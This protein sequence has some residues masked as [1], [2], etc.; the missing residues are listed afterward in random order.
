MRRFAFCSVGFLV[1]A[2][3]HSEDRSIAVEFSLEFASKYVWHGTNLVNDRVVQ[4][5]VSLSAGNFG[6]SWW[7]N[8]ELTSWNRPN[9]PRD[10]RGKF[11]EFETELNYSASWWGAEWSFGYIDYQMPGTGE[12]RYGEWFLGCSAA[13]LPG[14]PALNVY[15]GDRAFTGTYATLAL[16]HSVPAQGRKFEVGFEIN[17]G[18][19]RSS[20]YFY[21]AR[22]A[23]ATDAALHLSTELALGGGW[24]F[25]PSV[26]YSALLNDRLL[27]GEPRR[28]NAWLSFAFSASR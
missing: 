25:R 23:G 12:L 15:R 22:F 17:F 26:H 4:P 6:F 28:E 8:A 27:R 18:D 16:S 14:A 2:P 5:E 10:P 3:V 1:A 21:G 19:R 24:S 13:D 9:F 11:T 7:G 20:E